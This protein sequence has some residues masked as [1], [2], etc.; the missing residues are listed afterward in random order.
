VLG[1]ERE[2]EREETENYLSG[3]L[4]QNTKKASSY[5]HKRLVLF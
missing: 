5:K 2:R 1:G 4:V 3:G